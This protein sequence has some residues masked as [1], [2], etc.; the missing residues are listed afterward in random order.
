[1]ENIDFVQRQKQWWEELTAYF[2]DEIPK[3]VN[4]L[5]LKRTAEGKMADGEY[6]NPY[7][8]SQKY[9][10][11]QEGLQVD[12]KDLLFSGHMWESH[13]VEEGSRQMTD[14]EARFTMTFP[15]SI[16]PKWDKS[17]RDMAQWLSDYEKQGINQLGDKEKEIIS[18]KIR[19]KNDELILKIFG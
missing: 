17:N 8:K 6:S 18:E 7:S 14:T 9:K 2:F 5:L 16:N 3:E 15:D 11:R 10:R 4:A 13:G 12:K 19:L 1:M